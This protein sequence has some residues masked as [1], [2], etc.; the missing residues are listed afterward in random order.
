VPGP[1]LARTGE[2]RA[3][4]RRAV[5][6][7]GAA[8]VEPG[9]RVGAARRRRNRV[10]VPAVRVGATPEPDLDGR[11]RRVVLERDARARGVAG[12]VAAAP[13]DRRPRRVG[14]AVAPGGAGVDAGSRIGPSEGDRDGVVVPAAGV[15]IPT[16]A[17]AHARR[18]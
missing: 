7:A 2:R 9:P 16:G 3:V 8:T 12:L 14:A 15:R 4:T 1:V 6:A 5:V 13:G 11:R 18:R 10:V 17:R